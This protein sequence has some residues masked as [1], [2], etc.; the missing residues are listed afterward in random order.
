[1]NI[2]YSGQRE[3]FRF[4]HHLDSLERWAL[5]SN[6]EPS[7]RMVGRRD[8]EI[9][10]RNTLSELFM[11]YV[12]SPGREFVDGRRIRGHR[13]RGHFPNSPASNSGTLPK[14]SGIWEVSPLFCGKC[15]PC[16]VGSVPLVLNSAPSANSLLEEMAQ[17][18]NNSGLFLILYFFYPLAPRKKSCDNG[19]MGI[20]SPYL[21]VYRWLIR[22]AR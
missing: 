15:P 12:I 2:S 1:M 21:F 9:G 16:F 3:Y 14:F 10:R 6:A 5:R 13:I 17:F 18:M 22:L 19:E 4:A 11:N 7:P 20:V 8:E